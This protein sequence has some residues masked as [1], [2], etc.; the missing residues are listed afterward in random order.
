[1]FPHIFTGECLSERTDNMFL[2]VCDGVVIKINGV[3]LPLAPIT[4]L[5]FDFICFC[6][7][8]AHWWEHGE[9]LVSSVKHILEKYY[10]S[11][12]HLDHKGAFNPPTPDPLMQQES[13]MYDCIFQL[14]CNVVS[15]Q[16]PNRCSWYPRSHYWKDQS[17]FVW[18]F[19]LQLFILVYL[20]SFMYPAIVLWK[21]IDMSLTVFYSLQAAH[22][23]VLF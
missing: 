16:F 3:H 23:G 6:Y 11:Y 14:G 9:T 18:A 19:K 8:S 1:M 12:M 2:C 4:L 13:H 20:P 21:L 22:M 10:S 17:S 15:Q 7:S 5:P